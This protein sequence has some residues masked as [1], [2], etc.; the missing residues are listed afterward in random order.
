[1]LPRARP[2]VIMHRTVEK[3][4]TFVCWLIILLIYREGLSCLLVEYWG[5]HTTQVVVPVIG[6]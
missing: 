5:S 3:G 1:M 2:A 4:E 6:R